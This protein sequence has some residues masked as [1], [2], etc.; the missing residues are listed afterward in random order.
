MKVLLDK[1]AERN[2]MANNLKSKSIICEQCKGKHWDSS[3][4]AKTQEAV[5]KEYGQIAN[6]CVNGY[7]G[8]VYCPYAK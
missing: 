2:E 7:G 4:Q 6:N 8:V 5:L 1:K 3:S